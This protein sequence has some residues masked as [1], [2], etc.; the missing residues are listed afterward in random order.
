MQKGMSTK[1]CCT[2]AFS[3][4]MD[5][6]YIKLRGHNGGKNKYFNIIWWAEPEPGRR[7]MGESESKQISGSTHRYLFETFQWGGLLFVVSRISSLLH[8]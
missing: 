6:V 8:L 3:L 7:V 2:V 1:Y 4:A 5:V